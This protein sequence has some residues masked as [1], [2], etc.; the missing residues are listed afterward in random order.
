[1]S[2]HLSSRFKYVNYLLAAGCRCVCSEAAEA[3]GG[4]KC[5]PDSGPPP[6]M[7]QGTEANSSGLTLPLP[8]RKAA[9]LL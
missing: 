3:E 2:R 1:M 7:R 9:G 5:I 4:P 6:K 8:H